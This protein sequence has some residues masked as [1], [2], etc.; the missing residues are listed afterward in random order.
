[1]RPAEEILDVLQL[2]HSENLGPV[3]FYKLLNKFG[4]ARAALEN[5][6]SL[7]RVRLMPRERAEAIAEECARRQIAL[8][9]FSD[10]GYPFL[11]RGL[12]DAPPLLFARGHIECLN[13][14]LSLSV[15]GARNASVNGR[16]TA[17]R[18]AYELTNA[19]VMIVSGM[20]R[21]IDAAAHKGAMYA[22][23]QKGATVAVLGTGVD[24]PYPDENRELYDQIA[25]QG[26]IVSEFLPG[27]LP[28]ANNFPRRNRIVAAMSQGTLVTEATVKSGSL[29]TARMAAEA[30]RFLFAV[31]GSPADPR[32]QGPNRL[33]KE[34]AHLAENAEDIVKV[35]HN[36]PAPLPVPRALLRQQE[37]DF[38][39]TG[40]D[41]AS[42]ITDKTKIIDYLNADGVYVDEIIRAS[43]L[44]AAQVAM[45]LLELELDGA[46]ERQSGNKV[47]LVKRK[48]GK[49]Q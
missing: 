39:D 36:D 7:R 49:S 5:V 12:P 15:V 42:P 21:G 2:I 45:E 27:T 30:G 3:T 18:I 24:I 48:N 28:Q 23:G 17:S 22:Q 34:G 8:I 6:G 16:K 14:P 47:A 4:S 26:C 35:L 25:E 20:A 10:A 31:P 41:L 46:I 37:L 40:T 43:G 33:I 13:H 9:S 29:I 38:A 32:S 44:D 19:G 11:L 1:M